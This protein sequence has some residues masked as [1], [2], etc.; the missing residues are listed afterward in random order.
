MNFLERSP[1]ACDRVS[2]ESTEMGKDSFY[3]LTLGWGLQTDLRYGPNKE[4]TLGRRIIAP[5]AEKNLTLRVKNF[6]L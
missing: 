1:A 4:P 3:L 2:W 6:W 5:R